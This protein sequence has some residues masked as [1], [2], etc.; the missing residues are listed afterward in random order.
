[1]KLVTM[2]L[3]RAKVKKQDGEEGFEWLAEDGEVTAYETKLTKREVDDEVGAELRET[4]LSGESPG[5]K[6]LKGR[7]RKG[8]KR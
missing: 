1:V 4:D 2:H 5:R 6:M 7:S 8:V 3:N